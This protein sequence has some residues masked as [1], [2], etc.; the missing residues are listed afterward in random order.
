MT[1]STFDLTIALSQ[2][3]TSYNTQRAYFRWVDHFLVDACQL[4]ATRGDARLHR[5]ANLPLN[6]LLEVLNPETLRHWLDKLAQLD[7]SRQGLDQARATI[8]T[9]ADLLLEAGHL[10]STLVEQLHAVPVPSISRNEG[11]ARLLDLKEIKALVLA[12]RN[13]ATSDTQRLRNHL[14][15]TMLCTLALRREELSVAR[16]GDLQLDQ[17]QNA[18]LNVRGA[19]IKSDRIEIPPTL[20]ESLL[21]WKNMIEA[22]RRAPASESP[23]VR[24]IWKGGRIAKDGLSPDGIWLVIRN[25]S[26]YAHLDAV[27]PDDLR[28]SIAY[29][30]HQDNVPLAQISRILRHR[31]TLI[32]ER[33]LNKLSRDDQ[34]D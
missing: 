23:I 21:H 7:H 4:K 27:T 13:M 10:E 5:M 19:G 1:H 17:H 12:A 32:T 28:R 11:Q 18:S 22:Q 29:G 25:A 16:W 20:Y 9:L 26:I 3:T 6:T 30:M 34:E 14:V 15:A 8:V 33:I 31:N 2:I 24:R